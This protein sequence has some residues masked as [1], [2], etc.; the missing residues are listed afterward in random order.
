M[1]ELCRKIQKVCGAFKLCMNNQSKYRVL[2]V[3]KG[4]KDFKEMAIF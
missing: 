3:W 2:F 1:T 4:W